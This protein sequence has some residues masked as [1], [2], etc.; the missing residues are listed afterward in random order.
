MGLRAALTRVKNA[1]VDW[2]GV[3]ISL[4]NGRAI[5]DIFGAH[6]HSGQ[7]VSVRNVLT[8]SA[9]W[10]CF[11][12]VSE[13]IG[14]LPWGMYQKDAEGS[15]TPASNHPLFWLIED[16]PNPDMTMQR[17]IQLIVVSLMMRNNAYIEIGRGSLTG[18]VNRLDFCIPQ[19]MMTRRIANRGPLEYRYTDPYTGDQ[20]LIDPKNLIHLRG[21]GLDDAMG[22]D[23]LYHGREV[24]GAALAVNEQAAKVFAQG[25]QNSG[26][27]TADSTAPGGG[28]FTEK[29]RE[30][31]RKNLATFAGSKNAGKL[32]VLEAGLKYQGVTLSPETAQM[33]QTR[34]YSVEEVARFW[35]VPPFMIGHMDKSSSWA[36]STEVQNRV[37]LTNCLSPI[38]TTIQTELARSLLSPAE[39]RIYYFEATTAGLLRAD[40]KGRMELYA[41]ALQNGWMN[42]NTVAKLENMPP[43]PEGGDVYTVQ[44]NLIP[45][46]KLGEEPANANQPPQGADPAAEPQ[47]AGAGDSGSG[48]G[49]VE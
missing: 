49:S 10:A 27:L 46:D 44:S 33:L 32:M 3:P 45:I 4:R 31:I 2:N 39:R 17:F 5:E 34:G 21:F 1:I 22:L 15:R 48:D 16:Q 24:L 7:N 30:E 37:F 26:F 23:A 18:K 11:K 43:L 14:G 13:A 42:R 25:M 29:Q 41:S 19:N 9:A 6:S 28:T 35:S 36:S 47:S 40:T 8:L 20:R 38:I 12:V